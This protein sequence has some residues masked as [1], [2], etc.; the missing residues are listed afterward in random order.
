MCSLGDIQ[1][2][3]VWRAVAQELA[4]WHALLP[5]R[6][7][8]GLSIAQKGRGQTLGEPSVWSTALKWLDAL[9]H[10][11]DAEQKRK[12]VLASDFKF[13]AQR[14]SCDNTKDGNEV[15]RR[16]FTHSLLHYY[17]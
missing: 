16:P 13:L 2:K 8:G 17:D 14:L 9:P 10:G 4:R 3:D 5:R 7:R 15:R 11:T 12:D 1:K 6:G